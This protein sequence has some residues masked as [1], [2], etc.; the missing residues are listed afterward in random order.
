VVRA[1]AESTEDRPYDI[2]TDDQPD[3]TMVTD[4]P[5]AAR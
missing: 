3:L 4:K 1:T 5:C 2:V